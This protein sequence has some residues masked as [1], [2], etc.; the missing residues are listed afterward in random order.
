M[1]VGPV[2]AATRGRFMEA[3]VSAQYLNHVISFGKQDDWQGPG[4]GRRDVLFQ[5][6]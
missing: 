3:Y 5:Q 4:T 6:C 1:P 2:A